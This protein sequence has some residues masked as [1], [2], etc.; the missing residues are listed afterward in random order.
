MQLQPSTLNARPST[1][2][3]STDSSNVGLCGSLTTHNCCVNRCIDCSTVGVHG[4]NAALSGG[5]S[6]PCNRCGHSTNAVLFNLIKVCFSRLHVPHALCSLHPVQSVLAN[7]DIA[8]TDCAKSLAKIL[9]PPFARRYVITTV[10][11]LIAVMA[12]QSFLRIVRTSYRALVR[13]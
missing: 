5:N 9:L 2:S 6:A 4:A 1:P 10:P 13:F 12:C 11:F 3:N 7:A 8:L